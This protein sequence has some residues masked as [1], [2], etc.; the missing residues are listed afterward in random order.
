[1]PDYMNV[2]E[3]QTLYDTVLVGNYVSQL[4]YRDGWYTTFAGLGAA[5][6]VPFFNVRNRN[7]GLPYNNQDTRDQTAYGMQVYS[8]G[9]RFFAPQVA[10]QGTI[11]T[12]N[13]GTLDNI[14]EIQS[15]VWE[16][17]LPQHAALEFKVNQDI[18][19]KHLCLMAPSGMGPFGGGMGHG[20]PTQYGT[21]DAPQPVTAFMKGMT[22]QG[23]PELTARWPFPVPIDVP[24]RASLSVVIKFSEWARQLL[25][26]MKGPHYIIHAVSTT[27]AAPVKVTYAMFGI[28][29]SLQVKRYV[30]QRG[31]YHV[32]G[33]A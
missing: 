16:A 28:Q 2:L 4:T 26:T 7:H 30:Q 14:E 32:G 23:M 5:N 10:S 8:L 33:K 9:V 22:S 1:M 31:Q 29:V 20:D 12:L 21:N 18:R 17:D 13:G 25:Q 6:E 15:A 27:A 24:M 11:T 3:P 19:L